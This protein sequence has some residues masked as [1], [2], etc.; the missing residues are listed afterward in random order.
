[1]TVVPNEAEFSFGVTTQAKTAAAALAANAS[2]MRQVIAALKQAGVAAKDIQT[3]AV[4]LD[5]RYSNDGQDILGYTATN[6]VSARVRD[7][8]HAGAVVD[9]AVNAGAN[10][11]SGP[12]LTSSAMSAVYN[13]AL[14]AAVANA[15]SKAAALAAASGA[16][17]GRVLSI[18]EGSAA[19][20]ITQAPAA[21]GAVD[22]TPIQPG[23]QQVQA[24][25]TVE[26]ALA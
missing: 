21:K 16:H 14:R 17:V 18:V 8:N 22:T 3:A 11:V 2:Q 4:E 9:A 25:V 26:F 24:T 15:R 6:S 20:P 1:V 23:T 10:Q 19:T 13:R 5:P 12:S 7:I